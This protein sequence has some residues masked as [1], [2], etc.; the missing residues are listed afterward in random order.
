MRTRRSSRAYLLASIS[1]M[2]VVIGFASVAVSQ[3]ISWRWEQHRR[4]VD[5]QTEAQLA[6]AARAVLTEAVRWNADPKMSLTIPRRWQDI[7][8]RDC[9]GGGINNCWRLTEAD[10]VDI[11]GRRDD[12][13]I[14][15]LTMTAE[16]GVGCVFVDPMADSQ[17]CNLV[18]QTE[19]QLTQTVATPFQLHLAAPGLGP[20]IP[21]RRA[22]QA[23]EEVTF[24]GDTTLSHLSLAAP[25][26]GTG[27][28][29][30]CGGASGFTVTGKVE[31]DAGWRWVDI[32]DPSPP[33]PPHTGLAGT[34]FCMAA[35]ADCEEV[36][37]GRFDETAL[38]RDKAMQLPSADVLCAT[39]PC[40][41][42]LTA[43][44]PSDPR[45]VFH[46]HPGDLLVNGVTGESFVVVARDDIV[47]DI[48]SGDFGIDTATDAAITPTDL[49]PPAVVLISLTG[50]VKVRGHN[51]AELRRVIVVALADGHGL[52]A[53]DW[54]TPFTPPLPTLA[55]T[56]AVITDRNT[57]FTASVSP[58]RGFQ[59]KFTYP[60]GFENTKL[61]WWPF[62]DQQGYWQ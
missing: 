7:Y 52:Y 17:Q 49:D 40:D 26:G 27:T 42:D 15:I 50:D 1:V 8:G 22:G 60:D 37:L 29:F 20:E 2:L 33:T 53:E 32:C 31:A 39:P 12:L 44:R 10:L 43:L 4:Y 24:A 47:V 36:S 21:L 46:D 35:T 48:G 13:N 61:P 19:V 41:I 16:L 51:D 14:K 9:T 23:T 6:A 56:G 55:F 58:N 18:G 11:D 54:D 45:A 59:Q 34:T 30:Y 57:L 28:A 3:N 62:F 5:T 38:D 25:S